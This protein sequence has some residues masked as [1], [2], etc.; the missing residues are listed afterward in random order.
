[1]LTRN[2]QVKV[3]TNFMI[4]EQHIQRDLDSVLSG[5]LVK[6]DKLQM[7]KVH[8]PGSLSRELAESLK[9]GGGVFRIHPRGRT[10]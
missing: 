2:G 3:G 9:Q 8:S 4:P 10:V 6:D 5:F 1:M 7:G